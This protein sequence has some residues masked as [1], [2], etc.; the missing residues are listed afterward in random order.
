[1]NGGA[2]KRLGL[3][4]EVSGAGQMLLARLMESTDWCLPA[5]VSWMERELHKGIMVSA[6]ALVPG[7]S[8]LTLALPVFTIKL[9][10]LVHDSFQA[11]VPTAALIFLRCFGDSFSWQ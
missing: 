3:A 2:A 1:M 10:N 7:E 8:C 11:A 4:G 9:V 5:P 6:R